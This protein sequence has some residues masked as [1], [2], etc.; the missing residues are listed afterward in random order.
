MSANE[1]VHL[2]GDLAMGSLHMVGDEAR[3]EFVQSF[4]PWSSSYGA[5]TLHTAS[6]SSL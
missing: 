4:R 1:K 6:G 2:T 3:S 5:V